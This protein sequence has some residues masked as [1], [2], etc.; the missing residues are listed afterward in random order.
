MLA[1]DGGVGVWNEVL[2]DPECRLHISQL[3]TY[4]TPPPIQ[5]LTWRLAAGCLSWLPE[6]IRRTT[7]DL[8]WR[9]LPRASAWETLEPHPAINRISAIFGRATS[10][11]RQNAIVITHDV[12]YKACYAATPR[13]AAMENK[14]GVPACYYFLTGADYRLDGAVLRDLKAMGHEVGVHG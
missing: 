11:H 5:R 13:I 10:P 1:V 3:L 8:L 9:Y 14:L 2:K 7:G 6:T 4:E 12:D